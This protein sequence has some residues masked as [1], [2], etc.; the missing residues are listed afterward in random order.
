MTNVSR[1]LKIPEI[2]RSCGGPVAAS[3]NRPISLDDPETC[4]FVEDG[5]L[6]VFL[7]E[8]REGEA[9]SSPS[10]VMRVGPGRLVFGADAGDHQLSLFAKAIPDTTVRR[11]P[12]A[13]LLDGVSDEDVAAHVDSWLTKF[14]G[15]VASRVEPRARPDLLLDAGTSLDAPTGAVLSTRPGRVVWASMDGPSA[16]LG[17]EEVGDEEARL[18]PLTSDT[19]L[20]A[21]GATGVAGTSSVK[22]NSENRLFEALSGF[23]RLA[24]GAEQLNRNLLLADAANEEVARATGRQMDRA[25]AAHG[26]FNILGTDRTPADTGASAL[27]AALQ[28][29]GRHEGIEFR[30][31]PRR[32]V[33]LGQE[34]A[35]RDILS[36]S[37]IR[38]RRVKLSHHERWWI[39]DSGAMLGFRSDGSPVALLPGA[40]GG[41]RAVDPATGRS[42]R[43]NSTRA[44]G[45]GEDGWLF[46]RSLPDDRDTGTGDLA[47]F[48]SRNVAPGLGRFVGAGLLSGLLTL[49]PGVVVGALVTSTIPSASERALV[50]FVIVL[51]SLAMF[52]FLLQILQGTSLMR[53]E[54][55][56]AAVLSAAAWD[57]LLGLPASFFKG[58]TAGDLALRMTVFQ[59]MRDQVSV[60]AATALLSLAFLLATLPIL[61]IFDS[62]LALATIAVGVSSVAVI[63]VLGLLQIGPH[64]RRYAASR[65]LSGELLQTITGIGKIR[66]AGAEA[67]A[68]AVW[69]RSYRE[70]QLATI[71]VS[72]V[73]EH[74]LAFQAA[75]PA[76]MSTALF[77][78]VVWLGVGQ[79]DIGSFLVVYAVSLAVYVAIVGLGAAFETIA[80]FVPAYEQIRPIIEARPERRSDDS[81]MVEL[82]GDIRFDHVS[83]RYDP[84]G[85]L[86][87]DDASIHV[88]PGEFV[89][90]VGESGSGKSTLLR[91]ALGLENPEAGGVYFDGRDLTYLNRRSVRKQIGV[92]PQDSTLHPGNI[93]ENIIGMGEDLNI[94]D[95]WRAAR[96]AALDGDIAAMPMGMF[97]FVGD[98]SSTFSGG[99]MQ[100]IKIAAALVRNP[101]IVFL[102]EATSWLDVKSQA[103]VME[104][105]ESMASTRI[106][107]AHR[108]ST[109]RKAER[110]YV[111]EAGRVVQEGTFD[112]LYE[113]EGTFRTLVQRQVS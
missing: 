65:R 62:A 60:V 6:D 112:E 42:E 9:V 24:L 30:A 71:Q 96:L 98:R 38:S 21:Y 52:G 58:F 73:T 33:P 2:A 91:L 75:G 89:A 16:Y 57:G 15:T 55:R 64:R 53:L 34:P 93:M 70:Q 13:A 49:A 80:A 45:I 8:Y 100:R 79:F 108:L 67:S 22:L 10:H 56:A 36:A 78:V 103:K 11:V 25:Q 85:P 105:V 82:G 41:Y 7:A 68:F 74:L 63:S 27:L 72:R 43:M 40:L 106:V 92:V 59:T 39:G 4:W 84:D 19:W 83:F 109:I 101:R 23:H 26:L 90:I 32:R 44:R 69:A 28:A 81:S 95:A 87:I 99:Q 97:T 18:A 107:I 51:I 1:P 113:V 17:T 29:V 20:T 77:G 46:Y 76:L 5:A 88:R 110:I 3:G 12:V 102:D 104:G 94:D 37:G 47:R 61:F 54:G 14:C 111:M 50:Q 35:L 48:V 31:P 66:S 86:I